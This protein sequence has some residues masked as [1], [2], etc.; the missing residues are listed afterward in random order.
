MV[1]WSSWRCFR[2]SFGM[3]SIPQAFLSF[4]DCI[5]FT[6]S[7]GLGFRCL[8]LRAELGLCCS[9]L[10]SHKSYGV[11]CF[12]RQSAIALALSEGWYFRPKGQ[13]MAVGA[14]GP[15]LFMRDFALDRT[16]WGV[17]SAL[18]ILVSHRWSTLLRVLRLIAFD[19]LFTCLFTFWA[20]VSCHRFLS[21]F[22]CFCILS[23]PGW[24]YWSATDTPKQLMR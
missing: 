18:A 7:H 12:S 24:S 6:K 13:W 2:H 21:P 20:T 11:N 23:E 17:T 5:H 14:L 10:S 3:P 19:I 16:A 1:Q 4:S 9:L 15:T 8:Q 22:L